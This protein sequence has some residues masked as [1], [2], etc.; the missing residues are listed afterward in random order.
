MI[1]KINNAKKRYPA[2]ELDCS[3]EVHPG[4]IVGLIGK[5]G[6]GKSTTFSLTLGLDRLDGGEIELFGK[7]IQE[8]D[9]QIKQKLGVVL[10]D[11]TFNG[12]LTIQSIQNILKAMYTK[13]QGYDSI[14]DV[15][16]YKRSRLLVPREQAVK[17]KKDEYFVTD[18]IGLQVVTDEEEAFG[19]LKD[20]LSTGANDVYVVVRAD[21]TE[22]LLPAIKEC[23]LKVDMEQRIMRVHI[24]DGLL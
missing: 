5:N 8:L 23:I 4:E 20:V 22:V 11:S 13:F 12:N 2:F 3:M 24:M 16:K 14:N 6:A 1:L 7:P 9:D 10:S 17:L 19:E 15:E 21:G 18:M